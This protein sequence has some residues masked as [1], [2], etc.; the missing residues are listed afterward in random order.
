[1]ID[2][3]QVQRSRLNFRLKQS[4]DEMDLIL[5]SCG[6][7]R[8]HGGNW[9][10]IRH[11]WPTHLC[12]LTYITCFLLKLLKWGHFTFKLWFLASLEKLEVLAFWGPYVQNGSW[13]QGSF[14][15]V[16]PPLLEGAYLL[17]VIMVQM[18]WFIHLLHLPGCCSSKLSSSEQ[19]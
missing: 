16:S 12:Y 3:L 15:G 9:G 18:K 7:R 11:T 2:K 6:S 19:R 1:M 13:G 8:S 17:P 14:L 4:S 5:L 10:S